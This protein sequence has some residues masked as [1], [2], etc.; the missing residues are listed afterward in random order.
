MTAMFVVIYLE[1]WMKEKS[2]TSSIIG[3]L[4]SI[5]CLVCFGADSFMIPSM[6]LIILSLAL[7]R[8]K[9]K[10]TEEK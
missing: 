7:V 8:G 6:A 3:V 9:I 10:E 2:H 1:Q 5:I 4:V